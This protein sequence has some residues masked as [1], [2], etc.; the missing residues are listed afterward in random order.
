MNLYSVTVVEKKKVVD[1]DTV[2]VSCCRCFR[3]GLIMG[4]YDDLSKLDAES[5]TPTD[6]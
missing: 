4:V 1:K 5:P 6:F 2:I 3:G